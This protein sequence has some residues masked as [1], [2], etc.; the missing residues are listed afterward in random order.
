M[1]SISRKSRDLDDWGPESDDGDES[2]DRVDG[3][4]GGE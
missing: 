4:G 2:G 3:G 1:R